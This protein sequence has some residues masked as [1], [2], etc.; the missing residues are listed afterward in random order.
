M[1]HPRP[2]R[3]PLPP[4][5][6]PDPDDMNWQQLRELVEVLQRSNRFLI[7]QLNDLL[8]LMERK[9]KEPPKLKLEW[10]FGD[11][12]NFVAGDK[13]RQGWWWNLNPT[14]VPIVF[15]DHIGNH[16]TPTVDAYDFIFSDGEIEAGAVFTL[17]P[18]EA[19][20]VHEED[21]G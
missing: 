5:P 11:H 1:H 7:S 4:P 17:A 9:Q 16:H 13:I 21:D 12:V 14:G 8:D 6:G 10:E 19:K 18:L 15:T 2:P 20:I 3:P